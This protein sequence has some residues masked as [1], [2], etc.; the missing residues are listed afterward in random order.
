[1]T[2]RLSSLLACLLAT[3]APAALTAEEVLPA[4]LAAHAHVPALTLIAPPEDAARGLWVSGRFTTGRRVDAPM[5]VPGTTGG[6]HGN[7]L[8]GLSLPFIGQ[9][10]QGL[11]GFAMTAAAD[12]SVYAM[13]DNG[14][15]SKANSPDALL[16]FTRIAPDWETG[17]VEIRENVFLRD[18]DGVVPSASSTHS[19]KAGC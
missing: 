18:P 12:G 4:R 6:M 15:G 1:M 14:F 13:I 2:A 17:R 11:S 19:P 9:P 10:W 7:R 8:T 5:S 16:F 3:V